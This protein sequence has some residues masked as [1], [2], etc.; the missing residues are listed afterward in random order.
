[1][2]KIDLLQLDGRVLETLLTVF[3]EMSVG[4]AAARLETNQSTVSHR[5]ERV[6]AV[7]GDNLFVKAGRGI[8]PTVRCEELIPLVRKA[9]ENLEA[10]A[11]QGQFRPGDMTDRFSISATDYERSLFL[12]DAA[13][14]MLLDA[15]SVRIGF[16]WDQHDGGAALRRSEV[17]VALAPSLGREE[18]GLHRQPLFEDRFL[19]YFDETSCKP[20]SDIQSYLSARHVRVIFSAADVSFVDQALEALGHR[21]NVAIDAPSLHELPDVLAGT[22]LVATAPARL[23]NNMLS[24]FACCA[25]PV[26]M[27]ALTVFQFWHR[28]THAS[29]RHMWLR[30]CIADA[31][32]RNLTG[33]S[34]QMP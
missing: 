30:K 13:R 19:C 27:P 7:I 26:V 24:R 4:K 34:R 32:Q 2:Q 1:M 15:P 25:P 28:R 20:P 11:R 9:L 33:S 10:I 12:A 3:D 8:V 17:D 22:G 16:V 31:A 6:R 5:I 29:P 21:R 14:A 23:K 18:D